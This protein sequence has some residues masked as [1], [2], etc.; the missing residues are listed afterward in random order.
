MAARGRRSAWTGLSVA[1]WD[2]PDPDTG[3]WLLAHGCFA[4]VLVLVLV[5]I[6]GVIAVRWLVSLW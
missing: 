1:S 5:A 2:K 4:V 6:G 3:S